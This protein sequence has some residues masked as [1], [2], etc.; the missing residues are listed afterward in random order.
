MYQCQIIQTCIKFAKF[1][2]YVEFFIE[3]SKRFSV[4]VMNFVGIHKTTANK[5]ASAIP[6]QK[7][8]LV[9]GLER[10]ILKTP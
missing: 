9:R 5:A 1:A 7:Y 6:S 4:I 10:I 8:K 3:F 2:K